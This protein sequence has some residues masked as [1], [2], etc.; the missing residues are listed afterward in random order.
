MWTLTGCHRATIT[1][2][3][4]Q[5]SSPNSPET[6]GLRQLSSPTVKSKISGPPPAASTPRRSSST[7]FTVQGSGMTAAQQLHHM[8]ARLDDEH[9]ELGDLVA[10]EGGD[11]G[12]V[13]RAGAPHPGQ[14]R[15]SHLQGHQTRNHSQ[16]GAQGRVL[17]FKLC[18][19]ILRPILPS[20]SCQNAAPQW[21]NTYDKLCS[22][23]W[24]PK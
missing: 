17:G 12:G 8:C 21:Y 9:H 15:V 23:Q 14:Q 24:V 11:V 19:P 18:D 7:T 10:D 3:P 16:I 1:S 13:G 2:S 5:N 4:T 20:M 6:N 22:L